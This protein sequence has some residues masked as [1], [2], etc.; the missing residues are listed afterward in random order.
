ML[1]AQLDAGIASSIA[2]D[3]QSGTAGSSATP[4]AMGPFCGHCQKRFQSPGKLTQ[5]ERVH[6]TAEIG[7]RCAGLYIVISA[8]LTTSLSIHDSSMYVYVVGCFSSGLSQRTNKGTALDT[9]I[10]PSVSPSTSDPTL[11]PSVSPTASDPTIPPGTVDE[12][13]ADFAAGSVTDLEFKHDG[14]PTTR[15]H[16]V[17]DR[18]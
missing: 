15:P 12:A 14:I 11:S 10:S 5:H 6:A 7:D 8:A 17:A 16:H 9:T 18:L 13:T 1:R 3:G 2:S 4:Q